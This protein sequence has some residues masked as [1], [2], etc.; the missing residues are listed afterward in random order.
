LID[1][2]AH[3]NSPGGAGSHGRLPLGRFS[4]N[5]CPLADRGLSACREHTS[6]FIERCRPFG[7]EGA[8]RK[9]PQEADRLAD[10]L[11]PTIGSTQKK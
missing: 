1:D 11:A 4:S 7:F 8:V 3:E 2:L 6:R 5:I 9:A 10:N